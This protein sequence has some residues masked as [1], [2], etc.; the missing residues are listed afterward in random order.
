MKRKLLSL[1]TAAGLCLGLTG[2]AG[3][4]SFPT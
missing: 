3:A 2:Y 4:A 1:L